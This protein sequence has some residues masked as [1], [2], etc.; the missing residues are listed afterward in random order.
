MSRMRNFSTLCHGSVRS[1][2]DSPVGD[3]FILLTLRS[4]GVVVRPS[5]S[6]LLLG[7]LIGC[8]VPEIEV[9][10]SST[11]GSA[12]PSDSSGADAT[13]IATQ[14]Q[15][16]PPGEPVS[17]RRGLAMNDW[18]DGF[19]YVLVKANAKETA[20]AVAASGENQIA[21]MMLGE[22]VDEKKLQTIVSQIAGHDWSLFLWFEPES[23]A[24]VTELSRE[25][26][27]TLLRIAYSDFTGWQFIDVYQGGE[28]VEA[29]HWGLDYSEELGRSDLTEWDTHTT[30]TTN[31]DG[32]E[33]T[34]Q[35]LFR[36]KL[37]KISEA[38]L[39][40]GDAFADSLLREH[41][42]YMPK[43]EEIPWLYQN[44]TVNSKHE[45]AAF[46]SVYAITHK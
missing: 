28:S 37:R 27:T 29:M 45:Q 1:E 18:P 7:L 35:F 33:M 31:D 23:D 43:S 40:K 38:E 16:K 34:D 30:V 14:K 3:F 26:D 20:S 46:S 13:P 19:V 44:G 39:S 6:I 9:S 2:Q 4:I 11:S 42:A 12:P 32:I 22:P 21:E 5:L 8:E 10:E 24:F 17:T 36:S 25:M 15:V 41:D